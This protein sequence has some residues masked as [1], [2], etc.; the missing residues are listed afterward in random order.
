M[1][2]HFTNK[3]YLV[4]Y[5]QQSGGFGCCKYVLAGIKNKRTAAETLIK[6][7]EIKHSNDFR[8]ISDL[9]IQEVELDEEAAIFHFNY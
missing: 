2:T 9:K 4:T 7:V 3:A 1:I 6:E 8:K 5:E